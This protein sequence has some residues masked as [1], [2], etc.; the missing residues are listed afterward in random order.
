MYIYVELDHAAY[1]LSES[2][3]TLNS[4]VS[5]YN[6]LPTLQILLIYFLCFSLFC[7]CFYISTYN[8]QHTYI[9]E[10]Y[11]IQKMP[12]FSVHSATEMHETVETRK[13]DMLDHDDGFP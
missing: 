6:S 7:F 5:D 1:F 11:R 8:D 4:K 13:I 2:I 3:L 10:S 9:A 12:D